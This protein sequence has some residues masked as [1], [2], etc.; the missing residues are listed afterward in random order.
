VDALS[1]GRVQI[2]VGRGAGGGLEIRQWGGSARATDAMFRETLEILLLGFQNEFL[3][4]DGDQYH[5]QDLWMELRPVQKP[6]PPFWYAGNPVHA[7]EL[8]MNFI[9]AGP[10]ASVKGSVAAY[11]QAW[12]AGQADPSAVTARLADPIYGAMRH[13]FVADSDAEALDR[14]R[15]AYE[16]YRKHYARPTPPGAPA[17]GQSEPSAAAAGAGAGE[18]PARPRF[19]PASFTVDEAVAAELLLVGSPSTIRDHV[20]RYEAE[21]D[22]NYYVGAFSWGDLTHVESSHS[23]RLF[24]EEVMPAVETADA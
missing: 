11:R 16:A 9:G 24:A 5:Y 1:H 17:N 20:R 7:G 6:H 3:T 12:A 19:T 8:G 21:S 18:P 13:V 2:G 15:V 22:A 10:I 14:A 23:L 4:Y